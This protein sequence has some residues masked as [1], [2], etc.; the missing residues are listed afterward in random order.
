MIGWSNGA[1][2][3]EEA[4]YHVMVLPNEAEIT[5]TGYA[6]LAGFPSYPDGGWYAINMVAG[7]IIPW[8][9]PM[10]VAFA[11]PDPD[12]PYMATPNFELLSV[13]FNLETAVSLVVTDTN[14]E[15]IV[16]S[17]EVYADEAL[18]DTVPKAE[19]IDATALGVTAGASV[20]VKAKSIIDTTSK[21]SNAVIFE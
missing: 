8:S 13:F 21:A 12:R 19:T 3:P 7:Q 1:L 20:T 4:G 9:T 15:G 11:T 18:V 6:Y 5:G 17:Y 10:T 2:I 16:A 14:D